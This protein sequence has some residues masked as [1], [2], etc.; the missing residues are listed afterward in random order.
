[1]RDLVSH[2]SYKQRLTLLFFEL[3][4]Q[5]INVVVLQRYHVTRWSCDYVIVLFL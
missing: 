2:G 1:M 4:Y 3:V 5:V